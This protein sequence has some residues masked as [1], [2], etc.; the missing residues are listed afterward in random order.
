MPNILLVEDD[1]DLIEAYAI[2]LKKAK[3]NIKKA[4]NGQEALEI[5]KK[6]SPD[7]IILDLIMP[8]KSG[9]E[10]LKEY[11]RD[12]L[13]QKVK[14]VV[15]SNTQDSDQLNELYNL[16]VDRYII[17]SWTGPEGL[18]KVVDQLLS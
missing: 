15:F 6:F 17:K 4:Y 10:F 11:K 9:V 18:V 13:H 12:K 3:H 2:V 16:G 1:R 7:I 5:T 8:I 14:I